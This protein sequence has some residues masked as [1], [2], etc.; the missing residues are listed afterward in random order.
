MKRHLHIALTIFAIIACALGQQ[1]LAAIT[2]VACGAL[3]LRPIPGQLNVT[4]TVAEILQDVISSWTSY[5]PALN[6]MGTEWTGGTLKL[7]Q[8]YIA[9]IAGIPT[10]GRYNSSGTGF[11]ITTGS[12]DVRTLLTD[13]PLTT[14]TFPVMKLTSQEM[15]IIK[16]NKNTYNQVIANGG[17]ALAKDYFL[18]IASGFNTPNFSYGAAVAAEDF[19]F[20]ILNDID[21]TLNLQGMQPQGRILL[22]STPVANAIAADTT[23]I[24]TALLYGQLV[25]GIAFRRW[26]GICGFEEIIE[27][28][29]LPANNSETTSTVSGIATTDIVTT[30]AAHGLIVGDPVF[31]AS[32][33]G[34]GA[35]LTN[36]TRYYV[37]SVPTTTT[38][39]VSATPGGT[40]VDVT[41][42]YTSG[43]IQKR[44][45]LIAFA[46]TRPAIITKAGIPAD[47]GMNPFGGA[48]RTMGYT[49][50]TMQSGAPNG[51][52]VES[53]GVSMAAVDWQIQGKGDF[54][55]AMGYIFGKSLGRQ[56]YANGSN[57][58]F[59][60][61]GYRFYTS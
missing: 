17:L 54:A 15:N 55:L 32:L 45:N 14:D 9:H 46:F 22:V 52:A 26:V 59:D 53:T 44:E 40:A 19:D 33:A 24:G 13:I 23:R 8:Q 39:K 29:E 51:Q 25:R 7:N 36:G 27:V 48:S 16:D 42:A 1:M 41:T 5:V 6:K 30:S 43:T 2:V 56:S 20:D 34:G 47:F 28:P 60:K 37:E 4:L 21:G 61:Q 11:D 58:L 38:L 57:A 12:T 35:G 49:S 3:L 31:F 10:V 18:S 50:V